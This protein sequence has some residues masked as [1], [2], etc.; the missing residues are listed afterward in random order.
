I[1]FLR[2]LR[3]ILLILAILLIAVVSAGIYIAHQVNSE[4]RKSQ[5]A[6]QKLVPRVIT[7]AE[8][9]GKTEF[10]AEPKVGEITELL[11]G[12]PAD[13]ERAVLTVVGSEGADF[14]DGTGST[15]KQIRFS[16]NGCPMELVRLDAAGNYGFLTRYQ[17]WAVDTFLLDKQGR[18]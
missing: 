13:Q 17:S 11:T 8:K 6:Q 15:E 5:E 1:C 9:F 7:G 16:R 10:Y 14:V 3:K 2:M 4:L 12:W 18:E